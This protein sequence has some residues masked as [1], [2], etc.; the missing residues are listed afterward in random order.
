[1]RTLIGPVLKLLLTCGPNVTSSS[2][3]HVTV[4]SYQMDRGKAQ[5]V[6]DQE[7]AKYDRRASGA[8]LAGIYSEGGGRR[9]D[10]LAVIANSRAV[11]SL[12]MRAVRSSIRNCCLV[13]VA[14]S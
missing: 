4:E 2:P 6:A 8:D 10:R 12:M 9:R 14:L 13:T 5:R 7:Y 11:S 3:N 1:M